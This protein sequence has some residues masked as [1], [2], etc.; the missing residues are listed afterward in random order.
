MR[1]AE[2]IRHLLR[3]AP[4]IVLAVVVTSCVP[5]RADRLAPLFR[6]S[7]L[8]DDVH[9]AL[10]RGCVLRG[11]RSPWI[12]ASLGRPDSAVGTGV[13]TERW[14]FR[15]GNRGEQLIVWFRDSV[16]VDWAVSG[17]RFADTWPENAPQ[18]SRVRL[19]ALRQFLLQHPEFPDTAVYAA[20]ALCPTSGT[21]ATV[22]ETVLGIPDMVRQAN[23]DSI[24]VWVYQRG[25]EGQL[26]AIAVREGAV[27][28]W[29]M[30]YGAQLRTRY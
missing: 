23:A 26:F 11:M 25:R 5:S 24:R 8:T 3:L 22:V 14:Q 28:R 10:Y 15:L 13:G 6:T 2:Q 9:Y 4:G 29:R 21:P 7:A 27:L 1:R 20:A 16:V 18:P 17:A 12:R 19:R 30:D